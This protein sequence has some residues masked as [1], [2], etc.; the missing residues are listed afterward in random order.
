[1]NSC[2][3]RFG[4]PTAWLALAA[5]AGI[6]AGTPPLKMTE[7][8]SPAAAVKGA[9]SPLLTVAPDGLVWLAWAEPADDGGQFLR[10]A[11]YVNGQWSKTKQ[12]CRSQNLALD[13]E[14]TAALA[15]GANNDLAAIWPEPNHTAKFSLSPDRGFTWTTP[16]ALSK[17]SLDVSAPAVCI[18]TDGDPLAVW[19]DGRTAD[20]SVQPAR[21]KLYTRFLSGPL[22]A[23][24]DWMLAE[25]AVAGCPPQIHPMLDGGALVGYRAVDADGHL[26][27]RTIRL[28]NR[29]WKM[30]APVSPDSW[31]TKQPITQS[32]RFAV[33][34]GRVGTVWFSGAADHHGDRIYASASPE[35]GARFLLA[36]TVAE[37]TDLE[38]PEV[39]LLH[40]GAL[41]TVWLTGAAQP[42]P[43]SGA[44][45]HL[46]RLSPDLYSDDETPLGPATPE[47]DGQ[48]QLAVLQD[49]AG[50][51]NSAR[52]LLAYPTGGAV[53]AV[54]TFLIT[55]PEGDL[56]AT[57]SGDCH[58]APTPSQ[59][60][61]YPVR[62]IIEHID[63][64]HDS[65]TVDLDAVPGIM[66]PGIHNFKATAAVL[67]S[68]RVGSSIMARIDR[69]DNGWKMFEVHA[70]Q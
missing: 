37:G 54:H 20:K 39:A 42:K 43:G 5:A 57:A 40:D 23:F 68:A 25:D 56:L 70:M 15:A 6:R 59:L 14:L 63:P 24:P 1:M 19:L 62:G 3:L 46:R 13:G 64:D 22:A 51:V 12:I 29:R 50:D 16:A 67:M 52:V 61:G 36:A 21:V 49:Y 53:P 11:A 4:L 66:D 28:H 60:L 2:L 35:A 7:F 18:L 10:C 58:C 9:T 65:L 44:A 69:Q 38:K 33:D 55:I 41:L 32:L 45:L 30:G 26:I 27:A 47:A 48:P 31:M 17:E 34:G 8:G